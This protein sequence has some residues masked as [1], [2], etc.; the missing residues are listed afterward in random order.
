MIQIITSYFI[1][2]SQQQLDFN[3]FNL[4]LKNYRKLSLAYSV[5]TSSLELNLIAYTILKR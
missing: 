1:F 2:L 3:L 4:I 5:F